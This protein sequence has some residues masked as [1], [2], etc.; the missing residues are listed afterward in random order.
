MDRYVH[1]ELRSVITVL[2]AVAVCAPVTAAVHG[3]LI[4]S[5]DLSLFLA[6]LIGFA[7]LFTLAQASRIK[8]LSEVLDFEAAVPLEEPPPEVSLLRHPVNPWLLAVMTAGT[9]GTALAWEPAAALFPLWLALAWLG[10]AWLA[11][12]WER[13]NGKVLWRG[14]DPD[15]PWRL[16]VSPRPLTRTATGA[17]PE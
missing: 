4:D 15:K 8:W 2:A 12:N 11:V 14:H 6:G 9:L 5:G 10:Q 17:L 3:T 13:G 16:S 7:V 1:H